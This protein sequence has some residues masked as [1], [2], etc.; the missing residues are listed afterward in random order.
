MRVMTTMLYGMMH[1]EIEVY[2]NDV[3]IKSKTPA[4]HVQDMRKFF[5]RCEDMISSLI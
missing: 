2:V 1:K 5:K 4:N 3:I